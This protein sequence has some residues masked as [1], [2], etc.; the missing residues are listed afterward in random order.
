MRRPPGSRWW[1]PEGSSRP[2]V[3]WTAAVV[4]RLS[5]ALAGPLLQPGLD[6]L[7]EGVPRPIEARLDRPEI[8]VRDLGDLLVRL[9][10]ELAE[11]EDLAVGLR[12][13]GRGRLDEHAQVALPV[14]VVRAG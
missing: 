10:L 13:A 6:D 9:P 14:Q 11:H 2:T 7:R 1:P 3:R 5:S 4:T 12:Q 8:A